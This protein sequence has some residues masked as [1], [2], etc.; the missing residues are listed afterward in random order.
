MQ[1]IVKMF[2]KTLIII[3]QAFVFIQCAVIEIPL[4][5]ST[6][7][8]ILTQSPSAYRELT[9]EQTLDHFN[10]NDDRTFQQRLLLHG[11]IKIT[12]SIN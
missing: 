7:Q 6:N 11:K 5:P 4:I 9:F 12:N 8:Q 3:L 1:K 2:T 10:F